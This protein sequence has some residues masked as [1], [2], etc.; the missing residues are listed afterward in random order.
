MEYKT[1]AGMN[2]RKFLAALSAGTAHLLLGSASLASNSSIPYNPFQILLLGN[3][4]LRTTLLGVGTGISATMRS[5]FLTRQDPQKSIQ[6]LRYAY[7]KGFRLFDCADSYGTHG[8][9]AK[10]LQSHGSGQ[11]YLNL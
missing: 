1:N 3:S 5:S 9:M 11:N 10:A 8:L 6:L 4:K 7:D 2:R